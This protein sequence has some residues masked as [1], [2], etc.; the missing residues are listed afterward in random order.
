MRLRDRV[1]GF[2]TGRVPG[3]ANPLRENLP[4]VPDIP[5]AQFPNFPQI[6]GLPQWPL[7]RGDVR[8][9]IPMLPDPLKPREG[10]VPF[11]ALL[12]EPPL[13]DEEQRRA[14]P[15]SGDASYLDTIRLAETT[16]TFEMDWNYTLAEF[17]RSYGGLI[18]L[19]V[20]PPPAPGAL[21]PS[22]L[23]KKLDNPDLVQLALPEFVFTEQPS[24]VMLEPRR[25]DTLMSEMA[26]ISDRCGSNRQVQRELAAQGAAIAFELVDFLKRDR[27][28]RSQLADGLLSTPYVEATRALDAGLLA[29]AAASARA[30]HQAALLDNQYGQP[31]LAAASDAAQRSAWATGRN[32]FT[33][34]PPGNAAEHSWGNEPVKTVSEHLR[35]AAEVMAARTADLERQEINVVETMAGSLMAQASHQNVALRERAHLAAATIRDETARHR[36]NVD[37]VKAKLRVACSPGGALNYAEQ[38]LQVRR[39]LARDFRALAARVPVLATGLRTVLGIELALP[40][41]LHRQLPEAIRSRVGNPVGSP[42]GDVLEDTLTWARMAV[43]LLLAQRHRDERLSVTLSLTELLGTKWDQVKRGGAATFTLSG[44]EFA[45]RRQLRL[46][47]IGATAIGSL[48][49]HAVQLRLRLPARGWTEDGAGR[50]EVDQTSA[51]AILLSGV[52]SAEEGQPEQA[53]GDAVLNRAPLGEWSIALDPPVGVTGLDDIRLTFIAIGTSA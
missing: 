32:A 44:D 24:D 41:S 49:G 22:A 52:L 4:H 8:I 47:A 48:S 23:I 7:P 27:I 28:Y 51:P 13:R 37:I 33:N 11:P 31:A 26:A 17:E 15:K 5:D 6:P 19:T 39:R 16:I 36:A 10:P 29:E 46:A 3:A 43:E 34:P 50:R 18:G 12:Q 30:Q 45:G 35:F 42:T 2:L 25:L 20:L 14:D 9:A 21:P 1:F 53:V 40:A 38:E